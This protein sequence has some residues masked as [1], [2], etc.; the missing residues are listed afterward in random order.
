[1]NYNDLHIFIDETGRVAEDIRNDFKAVGGVVV[2]GPMTGDDDEALHDC[3]RSAVA[4]AGGA[5]PAD[6]HG[7]RLATKRFDQA[8]FLRELDFRLRAWCGDVRE[9]KGISI[10][11]DEDLWATDG[12]VLSERARDN[13][14]QLMLRSLLEQLLFLDP[15][16]S[17][18][19][20]KDVRVHVT[21]ASRA[22]SLPDTPTTRMTLEAFGSMVDLDRKEAGRLV[23]RQSFTSQELGALLQAMS[24]EFGGGLNIARSKVVALDYQGVSRPRALYLADLYLHQLRQGQQM[25]SSR[26]VNRVCISEFRRLHYGPDLRALKDVALANRRGD[27]R[28]VVRITARLTDSEDYISRTATTFRKHALG[29]LLEGAEGWASLLAEASELLEKPGGMDDG[30]S[31]LDGVA[32]AYSKTSQGGRDLLPWNTTYLVAKGRLTQANHRGD[33]KS[34]ETVWRECEMTL[35]ALRRRGLEGL[36]LEAQIR[37]RRAVGLMD[38]FRF[39]EAEEG[40]RK[41]IDPRRKLVQEAADN[42]GEGFA[43]D[44]EIGACMGTLGQIVAISQPGRKAEAAECFRSAASFFQDTH[45]SNRQWLYLGH[46]ACD[47]PE[48]DLALWREV[49]GKLPILVQDK[50]IEGVGAQFILALQLKGAM[51]FNTS[52]LAQLLRGLDAALETWPSEAR[53]HHPFGLIHQMAAMGA[54]RLATAS[55]EHEWKSFSTGHFERAVQLMSRGDALLKLLAIACRLRMLLTF[56]SSPTELQSAIAEFSHHASKHPLEMAF[57]WDEAGKP[58][59]YFGTLVQDVKLTPPARAAALVNGI[60]LNYW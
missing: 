17:R 8:T 18:R 29:K 14:Y 52:D 21:V 45:D 13:R 39:A 27:Y 47:G 19:L 30:I 38:Q 46:L 53:A 24:L 9:L 4:N 55:E 23:V 57:G 2:L 44:D 31:L 10:Q 54:A 25:Q 5:F 58:T 41:L 37:N 42:Y 51:V 22:L 40:L 59:G 6:L 36:Q 48:P 1:M 16:L 28:Q 26:S 33:P 43:Q 32:E 56:G 60:R 11:H 50:P 34:G 20:S 15:G 35:P 3:L 7:G 49:T 12:S